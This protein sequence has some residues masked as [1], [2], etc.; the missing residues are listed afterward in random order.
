[1][2]LKLSTYISPHTHL[3]LYN[4]SPAS[5]PLCSNLLQFRNV[6]VQ[7]EESGEFKDLEKDT[8][9]EENAVAQLPAAGQ[10]RRRLLPH[11]AQ[12]TQ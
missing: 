9:T 5:D 11:T 10:S 4:Q 12:L 6:V 3:V 8:G 7:P 2:T 1:M